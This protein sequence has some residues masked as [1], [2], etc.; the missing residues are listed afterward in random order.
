M[1]R[2]KSNTK[3]TIAAV[4]WMSPAIFLVVFATIYPLIFSIDY[5]LYETTIFTKNK[6][7]GLG[8][9]INL[10][11]DP[12]F[13]TNVVNSLVFTFGSLILSYIIGFIVTLILR[14]PSKF[15]SVC[16]TVLLIPWVTNEVVLAL[17]WQWLLNPQMSPLYYYTKQVGIALPLFLSDPK[18]VLIT[19]TVL[20]AL[21]SLGFALVMLLAAF[22]GIPTHIEEAGQIDGCG[23]LQNIWH[24]ILPLVKPVSLVVVIVMTISNFNIVTL[25]LT[26]TGGGPVY[27]S[28]ILPVRLYKEGFLF[29][30]ID[31][32]STMTTLMLIVNLGF[33][34]IYKKLI[35]AE[36]YY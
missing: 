34:A 21:R 16:R 26:M 36:S 19:I 1:R 23:K 17:L 28:E 22:S 24:I 27:A 5:S 33:A 14:R 7:V 11:K 13:G 31:T 29:F 30:N 12:R 32:A 15:N 35:S 20:N 3:N 8:N 6:F 9:Y 10:F 25:V 4:L 18:L 2:L